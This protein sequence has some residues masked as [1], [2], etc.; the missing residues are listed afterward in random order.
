MTAVVRP[1]LW[2]GLDW[3]DRMHPEDRILTGKA[4]AIAKRI[5]DVALVVVTAA[6]WVPAVLLCALA[7]KLDDPS[8]PVLF[9]QTRTGVAGRTIAMHK[10]RTMV[11]D[12]EALKWDLRHLNEL[13]WPDFKITDDPRITRPGRLLRK[14][15]LDELPQLW[16]VLLGRLSLVGPRPTDFLADTY[17]LWQTERLDVKPG[18]TGLWQIYGRAMAEFDDRTRLDIAYVQRR[19]IWLD[20]QILVRT[21]PA[22][23]AQRGAK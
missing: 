22:V 3:L 20:V 18:V 13:E 6:L 23:L 16:D 19:S 10:F 7:I 8:A 9:T 15:S 1:A 21:V 5:M 17:R 11:P 2:S 14:T 4:Y 12:A